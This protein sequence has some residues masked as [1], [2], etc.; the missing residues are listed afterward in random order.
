MDSNLKEEVKIKKKR[1]HHRSVKKH[2]IYIKE[3]DGTVRILPFA[4]VKPCLSTLIELRTDFHNIKILSK[5]L[6][7]FE[8]FYNPFGIFLRRDK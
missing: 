2:D 6:C 5:V 1:D 7:K 3:E 8:H 4:F